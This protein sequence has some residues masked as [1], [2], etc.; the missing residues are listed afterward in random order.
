M[1]QI[2]ARVVGRKKS[3][4]PDWGIPIPE[5]WFDGG[6]AKTLKNLI[7]LIVLHEVEA[8]NQ[9]QKENEFLSFFSSQQI[10]AQVASAGKVD[11]GEKAPQL[12]QSDQAVEVAIQ[13]FID[14]LYFVFIDEEQQTDL[15]TRVFVSDSSTVTFVRLVG[16]AGG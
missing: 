4:V 2:Q 12:A 9:R 3:F 5:D 14:G 11:F 16:L 10:N 6:K 15:Q 1:L 8:Y 13:A 7:A